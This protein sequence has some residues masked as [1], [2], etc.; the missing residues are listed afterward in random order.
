MAKVFGPALSLDAKGTIGKI[1]TYQNRPKSQTVMRKP[2][3]SRVSLDNPSIARQA[4]RAVIGNLVRQWQALTPAEQYYWDYLA[5]Q[6]G[7][8]IKGY[9]YFIKKKASFLI[10]EDGLVLWLPFCFGSGR[11]VAD[12]SGFKNNFILE[13]SHPSNAPLWVAKKNKISNYVMSF[14]GIDDRIKCNNNTLLS[15]TLIGAFTI[16]VWI[17]PSSAGQNTFRAIIGKRSDSAG[18][19]FWIRNNNNIALSWGGISVAQSTKTI[20]HDVWQRVAV[21]YDGT[22]YV[23]FFFDGKLDN[24]INVVLSKITNINPVYIGSQT[25]SVYFYSGQIA[26][27]RLFN[28]YLSDQEL[29]NSYNSEK[30]FFIN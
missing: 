29:I 28:R 4:Q 22:S 21:R 18:L 27:L 19:S 11:T 20:S 16:I 10:Q 2:S 15:N 12:Y 13:P 9:H 25:S 5:D 14:D 7:L 24:Q 1:L 6:S 3:S 17:K 23:R 26:L 30:I 8:N